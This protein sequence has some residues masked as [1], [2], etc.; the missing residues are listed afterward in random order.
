[1]YT[2][3]TDGFC[4]IIAYAAYAIIYAPLFTMEHSMLGVVDVKRQEKWQN[5]LNYGSSCT[6]MWFKKK[7]ISNPKVC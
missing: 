2:L 1:M 5:I 4:L 3:L 7:S 6:M